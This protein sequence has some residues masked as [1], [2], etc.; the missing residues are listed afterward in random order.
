[1]NMHLG[2]QLSFRELTLT[3]LIERL[4][5]DIRDVVL[6]AYSFEATPQHGSLFS[7]LLC[8][9]QS[10]I[11]LCYSEMTEDGMFLALQQQ[12]FMQIIHWFPRS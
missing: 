12:L 7:E 6:S 10:Y 3:F 2:V 1:M 4:S 9:L 8:I 11:G 5:V